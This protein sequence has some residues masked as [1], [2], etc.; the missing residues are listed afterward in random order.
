MGGDPTE[1]GGSRPVSHLEEEPGPGPIS[2]LLAVRTLY[3]PPTPPG[4]CQAACPLPL[5]LALRCCLF[6]LSVQDQL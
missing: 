5:P 4:G 2:G 6:L 1:K 3:S